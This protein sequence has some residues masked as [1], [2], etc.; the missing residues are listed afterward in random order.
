[1]SPHRLFRRRHPLQG[2]VVEQS[3]GHRQQH[4]NLVGHRHGIELGL[5]EHLPDAVAVLQG[6]AGAFIQPGAEAGEG[7]QLLELGVR[8]AQVPGH[9][10]V[11][12]QLRLAAHPGD[13]LAHVHRGEDA[14]SGISR[15]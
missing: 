2:D 3:L 5:L 9:G 13:R 12:G 1:M 4:G 11:G 7:L 8:Q 10:P 6:F 15:E 14:L